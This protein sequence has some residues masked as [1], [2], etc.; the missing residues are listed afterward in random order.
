MVMHHQ[1]AV[2]ELAVLEAGGAPPRVAPPGLPPGVPAP[3]PLP[4]GA[5]YF[6]MSITPPL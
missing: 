4:A 1:A 5:T 6:P 3:P 2:A